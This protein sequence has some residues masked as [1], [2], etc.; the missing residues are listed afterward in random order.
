[1]ETAAAYQA[2]SDISGFRTLDH[3]QRVKTYVQCFWLPLYRQPG[4]F[5]FWQLYGSAGPRQR[6]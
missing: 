3:Y 6:L 5:V 4:V 1:M 2:Y